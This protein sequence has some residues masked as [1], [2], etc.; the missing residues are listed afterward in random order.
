MAEYS[1]ETQAYLMK[2][3]IDSGIYDQDPSLQILEHIVQSI[4]VLKNVNDIKKLQYSAPSL[5]YGLYLQKQLSNCL[6]KSLSQIVTNDFSRE[7]S[8]VNKAVEC[9]LETNSTE[10]AIEGYH[11]LCDS[12]LYKFPEFGTVKGNKGDKT[13][14]HHAAFKSH[15]KVI[16]E[17]DP[18]AKLS[19]EEFAAVAKSGKNVTNRAFK[20]LLQYH[21]DGAKEKDNLGALPLHWATR[22]K[23]MDVESLATLIQANPAGPATQ[24]KS[25]YLPLHW[26]VC[27]DEPSPEIVKA[28]ID[29]HPKGVK[30]MCNEKSLPLHWSV[31]REKPNIEVV[32]SLLVAD[33]NSSSKT[34]KDGWLPLHRCVDRSNPDIETVRM[35]MSS[36]PE[37]LEMTNAEGH[38]PLHLSLDHDM[39][40]AEVVRLL[41]STNPAA[42]SVVDF[43]GYLPLHTCLDNPHPDYHVAELMLEANPR[44]AEF[45]TTE[46]LF[47][48][49]IVAQTNMDPSP[50]FVTELLKVS[51]EE[52]SYRGELLLCNS[53]VLYIRQLRS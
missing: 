24:D 47:P 28:L 17:M 40:S 16:P 8:V 33:P 10:E 1:A 19:E 14:L 7:D 51:L 3:G 2:L 20:T 34:D 18:S 38:L 23:N 15:A 11:K 6:G 41:V 50:H 45:Q 53:G 49:H 26:A 46:G 35:L 21:E 39:P 36:Y 30:M 22:N 13:L 37:A 27:Q 44:A 32:R 29:A 4:S 42:A 12:I 48:I 31:N 5:T 25:G 43:H 52:L 9:D